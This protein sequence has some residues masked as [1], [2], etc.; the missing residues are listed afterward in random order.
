VAGFPLTM[1]SHNDRA[2]FPPVFLCRFAFGF[3]SVKEQKTGRITA[4]K[5]KWFLDSKGYQ[6]DLS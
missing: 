2:G 5:N 3:Y 6:K 1:D 4:L